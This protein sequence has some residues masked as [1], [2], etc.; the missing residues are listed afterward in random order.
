MPPIAP[1]PLAEIAPLVVLGLT[2]E[3]F[4]RGLA[5]L[6]VRLLRH[7]TSDANAEIAL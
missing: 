2:T 4:I 7:F 5:P 6:V 1:I 3:F